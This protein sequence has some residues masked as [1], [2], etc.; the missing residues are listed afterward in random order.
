[1]QRGL[2]SSSDAFSG[3]F[4]TRLTAKDNVFVNYDFR[5]GDTVSSQN[6]PGLDT[7]RTNRAQNVV[8]GGIH[9]FRPRFIANFRLTFNRVRTEST[10]PFSFQ[11]DVAGD[12]GI[13]GTSR[14][15]IN[16][17]VP[18]LTFTNYGALQLGNPS[19][20][21]TQTLTMNGGVNRIGTKHSI[22]AG[23]SFSWSQRNTQT[24]PN[25][26]GTYDFT[27]FVTSAFDAQGHP[28]VG[29]GYD[30]ADFLLGY[31][32][33]A[34][35]RYGSSDNYLRDRSF[36]FYV[37]DNWRIRA[38]I[39]VNFG[40]RYEYTGPYYELYDRMVSLDVAPDFQAVAQVFPGQS[41]PYTGEFP[42]SL[43]GPDRNNLGP[44]IGL[45]WKPKASSHIVVR[46]GYGVFYNPSVYP[47]IASQ[48][49][50]QPPFAVAQ[51]TLT[52]RAAPLTLENGFPADPS[53]TILNSYAIDP[54]YRQGY[55]Q[56][57]NLNLQTQ[58][59]KIYTLEVGYNG[60]KGTRLDIL[61]APNRAP[62]GVPP[63]QTQGDL[64]ISNAGIF[65]YQQSDANSILHSGR[66]AVTRRFSHGIRLNSSYIYS[67]S[68]DNASGV[69]GGSLVV[70]QNDQN[71]YAE[72]SLSSFDQRHRF[73][74]GFNVELPFG[75]Q[76]KYLANANA[77]VQKLVGG[78]NLNG[79]YQLTSGMPFTAQVLGNQSNNSGTGS[80]SSERPDSTGIS[81]ALPMG[82]RSTSESFNTQAFALPQP[83]QFGNAGRNTIVGP[84][85]NILD[86]SLRK[87]FRLDDNNRRLEVR[88]QVFNVLNHPN[89]G[90]VGTVVNALD[91]G[92]V[93]SV[94]AMRQM[95]IDLRLNF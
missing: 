75:A 81:P 58:I 31:P 30:F 35:R 33:S 56:Q 77:F 29:T 93:T 67:K 28:Q 1:M 79:D 89:F 5:R 20:N 41:G 55:I 64:N 52:T 73:L 83:G 76:R 86:L 43:V 91:F 36:N 14:D 27:G 32:Y 6:F 51:N 10:N 12:L 62:E 37:Q 24:D 95:E 66:V 25:A 13:T 21:R 45:A 88:W 15:P 61:R 38:N 44:R 46:A 49:I 63:G 8:I 70:V 19:L 54:N 94:R 2:P 69:G 7:E 50:G 48:L 84:G 68:L 18:T 92:R 87:N 40:L 74:N 59:F 26:R 22:S 72:R 82:Q 90:S 11:N 71:I 39:T 53:V 23:G 9:R 3:R 47:Y 60:S 57:W 16:Y 78:W 42:R 80:L 65:L 34:S 17:G 85:N 4:N